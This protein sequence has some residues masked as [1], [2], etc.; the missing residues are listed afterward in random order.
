MTITSS[1]AACADRGGDD[2]EAVEGGVDLLLEG[3]KVAAQAL[4][5]GQEVLFFALP[6]WKASPQ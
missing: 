6:V 2:V 5:V 1:A 3:H 4:V